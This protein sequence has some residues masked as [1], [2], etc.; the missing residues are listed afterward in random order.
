MTRRKQGTHPPE[1]PIESALIQIPPPLRPPQLPGDRDRQVAPQGEE[2]HPVDVQLIAAQVEEGC[3]CTVVQAVQG[4][5][6]SFYLLGHVLEEG[7]IGGEVKRRIREV[8]PESLRVVHDD[9]VDRCSDMGLPGLRHI[10]VEDNRGLDHDLVSPI[11]LGRR[12]NPQGASAP[13]QGRPV[14][15]RNRRVVLNE[16][17]ARCVPHHDARPVVH[18]SLETRRSRYAVQ[19]RPGHKIPAFLQR[20]RVNSGVAR[21]WPFPGER[22]SSIQPDPE[23]HAG[24]DLLQVALGVQGWVRVRAPE[25]LL[26]RIPGKDGF[27]AWNRVEEMLD[28]CLRLHPPREVPSRLQPHSEVQAGLRAGGSRDRGQPRHYGKH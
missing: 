18:E 12:R 19:S 16:S 8:R 24:L 28:A 10:P 17:G 1:N 23:P 7:V 6:G 21:N 2:V 26:L 27:R 14:R 25:S 15:C 20:E 22:I 3:F 4:G 5:R 13:E 9:V 11:E